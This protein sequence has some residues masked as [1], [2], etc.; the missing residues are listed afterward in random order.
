MNRDFTYC[1]NFM[2]RI[3]DDCKRSLSNYDRK[4][5]LNSYINTFISNL[6]PKDEENKEIICNMYIEKEKN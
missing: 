6:N 1:D 3:S 2:C 4:N 5:Y